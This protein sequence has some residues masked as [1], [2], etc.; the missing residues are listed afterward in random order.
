MLRIFWAIPFGMKAV[1]QLMISV[2]AGEEDRQTLTDV[3]RVMLRRF[4]PLM[5]GVS[6]VI[7]LCADPFTRL[8]FHDPT[9]PV[10]Q[11]TVRGFLILPLCMPLSIVCMHYV[12][13]AQATGKQGLVNLLALVDGLVFV[14][15]FTAVLIPWLKMDSVYVANV[16][17]GIGCILVIAGYAWM[18]NRRA[19][20]T[21]EQLMV[22]P[23]GFGVDEEDR[24]DINVRSIDEVVRVS[25]QVRDFCRNRGIVGSRVYAASLCLEEMAGNIVEH[26]FT[27]DKKKHSIDIRVAH[28]GD[29]LILRIRDDCVPFNPAE[30]KEL[31][32][33]EDVLKNVGIRMVYR[34]ARE[35]DYQ[36]T[37]GLNVLTLRI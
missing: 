33:P 26:G 18:K 21:V 8:F 9:A 11:M 10:F 35:V 20:R 7:M 6:A 34:I 25:V 5:C 29:D 30:R 27:K 24:I 36:N 2:A 17:N 12:A 1:S 31:T 15:G 37:L 22:I 16:L 14:A 19:P 13:Y 3:M 4:V 23:E 32:D 28:K